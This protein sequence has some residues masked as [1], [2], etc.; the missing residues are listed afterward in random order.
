MLL[1][2]PLH[3]RASGC[4]SAPVDWQTPHQALPVNSRRAAGAVCQSTGVGPLTSEL[5]IRLSG[6]CERNIAAAALCKAFRH[7]LHEGCNR[8]ATTSFQARTARGGPFF[9]LLHPCCSP[10]F[11]ANQRF[12]PFLSSALLYTSPPLPPPALPL[13]TGGG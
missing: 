1:N 4:I 9:S 5:R 12:D 10:S 2:S 3:S 11:L 8:D 7:A 6:K 13:V